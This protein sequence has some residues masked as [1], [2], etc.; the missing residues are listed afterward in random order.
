M[1]NDPSDIPS[2]VVTTDTTLTIQTAKNVAALFVYGAGLVLNAL[3]LLVAAKTPSLTRNKLGASIALLLFCFLGISAIRVALSI[4]SLL[5]AA[6]ILMNQVLGGAQYV[7][8]VFALVGNLL[9]AIDRH[10]RV[11]HSREMETS[12]VCAV[13]TV[14]ALF[15]AALVTLFAI[16]PTTTAYYPDNYRVFIFLLGAS[17][18]PVAIACFTLYWRL[19]AH[20]RRNSKLSGT[21]PLRRYLLANATFSDDQSLDS[22]KDN[23]PL[24]EYSV[25]ISVAMSATLAVCYLPAMAFFIVKEVAGY[26]AWL[27][28]LASI[29]YAL[30]TVLAPIFVMYFQRPYLE[31][32]FDMF[33]K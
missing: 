10:Q 18:F 3:L 25:Q 29:A 26:Q 15:S 1:S 28:F 12:T 33:I 30:E 22:N 11:V 4:V 9:L 27:D 23:D 21:L 5:G 32:F 24:E 8:V 20:V 17:Y 14:G 6:S 13:L 19:F 2:F 31:A 16:A 7:L